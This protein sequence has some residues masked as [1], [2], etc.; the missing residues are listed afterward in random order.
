MTR[1]ILVILTLI[2]VIQCSSDDD[3]PVLIEEQEIEETDGNQEISNDTLLLTISV[4]D[5]YYFN[6]QRSGHVF[7]TDNNNNIISESRLQNGEIVSLVVNDTLLVGIEEMHLTVLYSIISPNGKFF[8]LNT[9]KAINSSIIDLNENYNLNPQ[10]LESE[11]RVVGLT[12]D[13][14][15]FQ[16]NSTHGATFPEGELKVKARL[17]EIPEDLYLTFKLDE[18]DLPRYKIF[19][20][21]IGG[22]NIVLDVDESEI[23]NTNYIINYPQNDELSIDIHGYNNNN[24]LGRY[25]YR[26]FFSI[27]STS[28]SHFIPEDLFERYR[29]ENNIRIGDKDYEI[30][31]W[32]GDIEEQ[33]E[34]PNLDFIINNNLSTSFQMETT[35]IYSF[36]DMKFKASYDGNININWNMHGKS[37]S[38]IEFEIPLVMDSIFQNNN[39][40]FS[41]EDLIYQEGKIAN[42]NGDYSYGNHIINTLSPII[43]NEKFISSEIMKK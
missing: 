10:N 12:S 18:E 30:I 37:D 32:S 43:H 35:S 42:L 29:I 23:I 11:I 6:S 34:I 16:F 22:E 27:G 15:T 14:N 24:V 4:D 39:I 40:I 25:L 5:N 36:Y 19:E 41:L 8:N 3:V 9:F 33:V 2:L 13:A 17:T 38:I 20:N 26:E 21:L 28:S 1:L 31:K 7:L